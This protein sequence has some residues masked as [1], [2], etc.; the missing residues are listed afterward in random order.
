MARGTLVSTLLS[1]LKAEC[2]M[3]LDTTATAKDAALIQLM[4]NKQLWLSGEYSWPFLEHRWDAAVA[5]G[6]RYVNL[7]TQDIRGQAVSIDFERPVIVE[8]RFGNIWVPVA[9]GIGAEQYSAIDPD[10][11]KTNSPIRHWQ[12][13]TNP[14]ES[15][16][17][18]QFE[19][20][21]MAATAQ[22]I[23]FT[24]Q[25]PLYTFAATTDRADLDDL[26]IVYYTAADLVAPKAQALK[27]TAAQSRLRQV[28]GGYPSKRPRI[29]LSSIGRPNEKI[30][31]KHIVPVIAVHG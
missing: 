30:E 2:G 23:R 4:A 6:D 28:R 5:V 21:P 20:W 19:V 26:L 31:K 27:I 13:S 7:P 12:L 11:G 14:N 8:V 18:N 15:A 1:M 25:R 3:S 16:N 17:A 24:G 29:N 22:T 10:L 9:Y